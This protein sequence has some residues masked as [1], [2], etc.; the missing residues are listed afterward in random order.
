MKQKIEKRC[1]EANNQKLNIG[2]FDRA[3]DAFGS[4]LDNIG[5]KPGDK[6]F[7]PAYIGWS[8]RERSGVF[9]PISERQICP[10]F[11]KLDSRLNIDADDAITKM[12]TVDGKAILLIHYFGFVDPQCKA[13]VKA[14]NERGILVIEDAAHAMFT[15]FIGKACG[16]YGDYTIYSLH[17]MLP[18]ESGGMLLANK[19]NILPKE[20]NSDCKY[21]NPFHYD[22]RS[23]SKKRVENYNLI[24]SYIE[25]GNELI[26]PLHEKLPNAVIPQ[27]YPILLPLS[28]R[29]VVYKEMND[30]G[31]GVVSLYHTMIN[32]I[33]PKEFCSTY[34]LSKHILNLP[35]HQDIDPTLVRLM[36]ED[37]VEVVKKCRGKSG[38]YKA[39]QSALHDEM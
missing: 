28:D 9:D 1:S 12:Q 10:V 23:I 25:E 19:D 20:A 29:N 5:I 6:V 32:S 27:T 30:L 15:D 11:Y 17:K 34:G 26:K 2:Y 8:S 37:L 38:I 36:I 7:L 39:S 16:R 31:W 35:V 18:M 14:A 21:G 3:R 4:V 24:S 22:F 33:E 13:I